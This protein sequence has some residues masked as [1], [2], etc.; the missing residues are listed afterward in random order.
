[1]GQWLSVSTCIRFHA[2]DDHVRVDDD[3]TVRIS[4]GGDTVNATLP[5]AGEDEQEEYLRG[6]SAAILKACELLREIEQ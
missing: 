5:I 1:M 3:G 4:L 2:G 6:L